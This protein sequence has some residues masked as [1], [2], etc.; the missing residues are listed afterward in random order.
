MT[1]SAGAGAEISYVLARESSQLRPCWSK[2]RL[3]MS[4]GGVLDLRLTMSAE[5]GR[6][7][8]GGGGGGGARGAGGRGGGRGWSSIYDI[9]LR[10]RQ[11][12]L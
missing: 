6:G 12:S 2:L 10:P 5:S 1:A 7:G 9:R 4:A 3:T 11:T 8:G